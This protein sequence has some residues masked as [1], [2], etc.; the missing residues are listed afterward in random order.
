MRGAVQERS[1]MRL[2]SLVRLLFFPGG[3]RP[4]KAQKLP[5]KYQIFNN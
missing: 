2:G 3:P 5:C 1:G 4:I